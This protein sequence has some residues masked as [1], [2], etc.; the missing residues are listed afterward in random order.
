[1]SGL[2]TFSERTSKSFPSGLL[3]VSG[4]KPDIQAFV[5]IGLA[6]MRK[7]LGD[8]D[9][10]VSTSSPDVT[11]RCPNY[12]NALDM[13]NDHVTEAFENSEK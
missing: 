12:S 9:N 2:G 11:M 5:K 7:R 6:N 13:C 1:M 8:E 4:V 10:D 3:W